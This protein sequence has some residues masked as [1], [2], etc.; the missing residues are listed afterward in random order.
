MGC[1]TAKYVPVIIA[2]VLKGF[3]GRNTE[4]LYKGSQKPCY[5]ITGTEGWQPLTEESLKFLIRMQ[6]W[7]TH[8]V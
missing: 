5:T 4:A 7:C 6:E 2:K 1:K 8:C 3:P